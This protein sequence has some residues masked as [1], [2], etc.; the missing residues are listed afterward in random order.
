MLRPGP[1]ALNC[2]NW[3]APQ[4]SKG[5]VVRWFH[6][7]AATAPVHERDVAAVAVRPLCED[8]HHGG[9]YVLTGPQSLTQR[10]QLAIIGDAIGR[11]LV[12]DEVSPD[13]ARGE[14]LATWPASA[15]HM[16]LSAYGAAV[17]RPALV[18]ST[19][20]EITGTPARTFRQ[21]AIDHAADFLQA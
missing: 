16:L 6:G 21:W 10:E 2:R 17:D 12:F 4:V 14:V 19:V 15:A 11:D 1:F 8:R 18:T 5:N 20:E 9:D 7:G 3:W 13:V